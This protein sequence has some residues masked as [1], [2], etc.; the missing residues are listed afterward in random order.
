M[1]IVGMGVSEQSSGGEMI[2]SEEVPVW[3]ELRTYTG[4]SLKVGLVVQELVCG[5]LYHR[6]WG[7]M[8]VC[9]Q[10][11][12]RGPFCHLRVDLRGWE[13]CGTS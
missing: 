2:C 6:F 11:Q 12:L 3:P 9:E 8:K 13:L 10:E 1:Q 7:A 5:N 4:G